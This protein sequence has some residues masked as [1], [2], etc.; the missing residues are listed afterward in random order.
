MSAKFVIPRMR[1]QSATCVIRKLC[2]CMHVCQPVSRT[3]FSNLM[4]V[5]ALC[6]PPTWRK[7]R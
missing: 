4:R 1:F 5:V 7:P 6:W 2:H 3:R